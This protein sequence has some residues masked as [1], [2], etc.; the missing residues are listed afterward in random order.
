MNLVNRGSLPSLDSFSGIDS[1]LSPCV[2]VVGCRAG[3]EV[4]TKKSN[5]LRT[6]EVQTKKSNHTYERPEW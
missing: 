3:A 2:K 6:Y 5:H 4:Q 1:S